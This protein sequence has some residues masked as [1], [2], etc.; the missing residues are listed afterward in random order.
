M[1]LHGGSYVVCFVFVCVFVTLMLN[2]C[3]CFGDS[4]CDV[5][6][7]GVCVFVQWVGVWCLWSIA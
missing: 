3:V 4:L 5:V 1:V 7:H 6:S 2:L